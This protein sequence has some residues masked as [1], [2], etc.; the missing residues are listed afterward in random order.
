MFTVVPPFVIAY[1]IFD[2]SEKEINQPIIFIL[3]AIRT[4]FWDL[5]FKYLMYIWKYMS[6]LFVEEK[7]LDLNQSLKRDIVLLKLIYNMFLNLVSLRLI[8]FTVSLAL[9]D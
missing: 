3:H 2:A 7:N 4:R 9:I 5:L 1:L 6:L 8:L